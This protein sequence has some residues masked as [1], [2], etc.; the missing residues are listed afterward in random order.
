MVISVGLRSLG[1]RQHLLQLQ[2]LH[3][4][5]SIS[6]QPK[7]AD[8][9]V[10][11]HDRSLS[12]SHLIDK[13][14]IRGR[15]TQTGLNFLQQRNCLLQAASGRDGDAEFRETTS[16]RQK[17]SLLTHIQSLPGAASFA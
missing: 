10:L 11:L 9:D 1:S 6:G 12:L 14:F 4:C 5:E 8:N 3:I 7:G 15:E 13:Q 16:D 17:P 2:L